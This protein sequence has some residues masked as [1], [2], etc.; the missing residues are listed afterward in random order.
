MRAEGLNFELISNDL[1]YSTT[2][3]RVKKWPVYSPSAWHWSYPSHF[4]PQ[5]NWSAEALEPAALAAPARCAPPCIAIFWDLTTPTA[6][7]KARDA[8][9][10][11]WSGVLLL[12]ARGC[13]LNFPR[14]CAYWAGYTHACIHDYINPL[15][16]LRL[17][18]QKYG[19]L[20][21]GLSALTSWGFW[22]WLEMHVCMYVRRQCLLRMRVYSLTFVALIH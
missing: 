14:A 3:Q 17:W 18:Q 9:A 11:Y 12:A 21:P 19:F 2:G 10:H 15:Y 16:I 1:W 22:W 13:S 6:K 7:R 4:V 20:C 5:M 8:H